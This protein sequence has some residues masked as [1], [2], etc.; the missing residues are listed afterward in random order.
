MTESCSPAIVN[1]ERLWLA[2][3]VRSRRWTPGV[4]VSVPA[5][6]STTSGAGPRTRSGRSRPA[7]A[8]ATGLREP[9]SA[10][11][12]A[13]I[14][15]VATAPDAAI[16]SRLVTG[17]PN[18][19]LLRHPDFLKLWTAETISVFGSAITQLALPLIAATVLEVGAFEFGLL[20]TI[21]FLPFILLSLPAGVWVDRLRRRPILIAARPRPGDRDRH[22]PG[23][24]LLRRADD[25]AAVHR[26]VRQRLPDGVLRRRVPEL[27]AVGRRTGPA[28]RGQLEAGDHPVGGPDPG[29]RPRG[30]PDRRAAGAVRDAPGLDLVPRLRR[31]PVLDPPCPSRRSR[32]I[33]RRRAP[34]KPSMR[35]DIAIGLRY[36]LGHRWLR[37]IAATTGTSNF[38]S[39]VMRRDPDAVPGP[40]PRARC[41]RRSGSRSRSAPSGVLLA[42]L[43][44]SWITARVGVGR[45]LVAMAFGFSLSGLPVA[46]A[47]D[48]LI[49]YGRGPVRVPRRVLR[50]RLEHQPGVAAPG[51]HAAPDAGP[52]ERH[53][54]VHRV[55]HDADRR[56]PRRGAGQHHRAPRHDRD[57]RG[58]RSVRVPAGG[59]VVGP[60]DRHD[61][62]AGRGRGA[63]PRRPPPRSRYPSS[64]G[65]RTPR[66]RATSIARS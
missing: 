1:T 16:D 50:R 3:E 30:H 34:P 39:N 27:P 48:A 17:S 5:S 59:A 63:G 47:P 45:M 19:S 40:R 32:P 64:I 2:S 15:R 43:T 10:R 6:R 8:D 60:Q 7:R 52:D 35:Q 49:W 46:F 44:T 4:D 29:P 31:V 55:G 66:S 12:V 21:E 65:I 42:A 54:A 36:V 18:R 38:F 9:R 58:R 13:A 33:T 26:R 51:D 61:A 14:R 53:H 11:R 22:H 57:R 56:D 41:R 24:V 20:T 62:R 37:Y 23:R 28:G 25:L